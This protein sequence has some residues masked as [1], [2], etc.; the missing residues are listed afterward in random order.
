[1]T[2][3]IKIVNKYGGEDCYLYIGEESP[4][5]HL[6]DEDGDHIE[7]H[8]LFSFDQN[9]LYREQGVSEDV[10]TP[11]PETDEETNYTLIIT[12]VDELWE[13]EL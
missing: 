7:G 8:Y 5:F 12:C 2:N 9:G 13:G 4:L 6:C 10:L 3:R 1:M 11:P